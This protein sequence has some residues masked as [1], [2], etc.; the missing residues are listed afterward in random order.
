MLLNTQL[1]AIIRH[2]IRSETLNPIK[3]PRETAAK[4]E[5]KNRLSERQP[6]P[7]TM[8]TSARDWISVVEV[9]LTDAS[10]IA[11]HYL[12]CHELEHA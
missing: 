11:S 8:N 12:R 3:Q 4:K 7:R 10:P 6:L 5:N 2:T 9:T 1:K